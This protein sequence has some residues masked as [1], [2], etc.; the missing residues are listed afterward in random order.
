M[1]ANFANLLMK[2][3]CKSQLLN[4]ILTE[5]I[6]SRVGYKICIFISYKQTY[7]LT[8]LKVTIEGRGNG[9]DGQ[10][11]NIAHVF[12]FA[13]SFVSW[14]A[15]TNSNRRRLH[16][17]NVIESTSAHKNC[18]SYLATHCD[19]ITRSR[20]DRRFVRDKVA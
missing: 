5:T 18:Q 14:F 1:C 13:C 2:N 20:L 10:R 17:A 7:T 8:S 12:K 3:I 11:R 16:L 6:F 9:D 19:S 15:K 4:V